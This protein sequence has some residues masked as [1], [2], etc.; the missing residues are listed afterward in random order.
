MANPGEP[1]G[2]EFRTTYQIAGAS[3]PGPS[4]LDLSGSEAAVK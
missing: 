4:R 1:R 2:E 3:L